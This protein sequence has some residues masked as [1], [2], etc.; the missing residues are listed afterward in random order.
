MQFSSINYILLVVQQISKTFALEER[1]E[2]LNP[3]KNP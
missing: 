3:L 1:S 2:T